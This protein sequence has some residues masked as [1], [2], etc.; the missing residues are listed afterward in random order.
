MIVRAI[1]DGDLTHHVDM[2]VRLETA[3]FAITEALKIAT[4]SDDQSDLATIADD[5]RGLVRWHKDAAGL[6]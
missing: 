2:I 6:P 4:L 3:L 1:S 5:I